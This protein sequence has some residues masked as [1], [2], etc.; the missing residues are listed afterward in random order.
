[1]EQ[2][3]KCLGKVDVWEQM[4]VAELARALNLGIGKSVAMRFFTLNGRRS[5]KFF[6]FIADHVQEAMLYVKNAKNNRPDATIEDYQTLKEIAAKCGFKI[7]P[8]SAP[9]KI[10]TSSAPVSIAGKDFLWLVVS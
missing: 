7:N 4:T 2:K 1:M 8:V 10:S 5:N 6:S 9:H 3:L